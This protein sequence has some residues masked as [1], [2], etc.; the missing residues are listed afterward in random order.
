MPVGDRPAARTGSPPPL[1]RHPH[2]F[3]AVTA[4]QASLVRRRHWSA[5]GTRDRD[6]MAK[7]TTTPAAAHAAPPYRN[8]LPAAVFVIT[9][10]PP[11]VA[12]ASTNEAANHP[13]A[14]IS[15]PVGL[16]IPHPAAAAVTPI[17]AANAI[18]A[19]GTGPMAP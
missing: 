17:A 8:H 11:G 19:A 14:G 15:P 7:A 16:C 10:L 9:T 3:P 6:V 2:R 13:T 5:C 1:L 4:P 12:M 18:A